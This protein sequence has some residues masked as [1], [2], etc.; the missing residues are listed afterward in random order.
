MNNKKEIAIMNTIHMYVMARI[1]K[2]F[3][4][5]E[6]TE[7]YAQKLANITAYAT[8]EEILGNDIP[9]EDKEYFVKH[10][11]SQEQHEHSIKEFKFTLE[12]CYKNFKA[13]KESIDKEG[14]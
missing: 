9:E 10:M 13:F 8:A 12:Q 6:L 14:N 3:D 4:T 11:I 2:L 7:M 1:T 5:D